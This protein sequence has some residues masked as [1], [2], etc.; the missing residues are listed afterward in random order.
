[1]QLTDDHIGYIIKDLNYRG[2]VH[3]GLQEELIDHIC[4][5][6]EK[7]MEKGERFI[8]AYHHVLK[9]FGHTAGLRQT[10]RQTLQSENSKSKIMFKN[11]FTI[12]IRNL[13]KHSFYSFI[14]IAGLSIGIAVC[15]VILL[16]VYNEVSYDRHHAKAD[17][18]YRINAD[19]KFGGN[20]YN[21]T[22]GPAPLAATLASDYPE[23]E[24]AIR[25]RERGS[26]L[27]EA[28]RRK[29]KRE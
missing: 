5:A 9:S 15:F 14:N 10:Q 6:V 4:S 20:H 16:F 23:V 2:I 24:V 11:Y 26:Y 28:Q 3:D 18:V 27:G 21:M 13:R 25:F 12:A 19:I 1:M 22:Y 7:E 8:D 29:H 17:R